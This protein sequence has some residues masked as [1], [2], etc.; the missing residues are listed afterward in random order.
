MKQKHSH[1]GLWSGGRLYFPWDESNEW[2]DI[3]NTS[4]MKIHRS[5][6]R[7]FEAQE[8]RLVETT[9]KRVR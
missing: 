1:E 3:N 5:M 6:R 9:S 7:H 8:L 4:I 2:M